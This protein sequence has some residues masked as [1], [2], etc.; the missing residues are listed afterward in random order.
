MNTREQELVQ[1]W[2]DGELDPADAREAAR[3]VETDPACRTL[4]EN[5]RAFSGLLR[6][7]EPAR[8]VPE[9]R[10]FYWSR[11][12]RGIEQAERTAA[13]PQPSPLRRWLPWLIP[14]GAAALAVSLMMRPPA[15]PSDSPATAIATATAQD[16][17]P[18]AGAG[19]V[20]TLAE[21]EV[22]AVSD[23][24]TT[25]TFYSSQDAMTV[26]WLGQVDLL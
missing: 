20:P 26:V 15:G 5:L 13:R 4:A 12:R 1:A 10:E 25:L 22:E 23:Q 6:D 24:V 18:G 8:P 7:H 21:H 16:A 19:V 3:L 14:A 2:V 17:G 11:I 9:T